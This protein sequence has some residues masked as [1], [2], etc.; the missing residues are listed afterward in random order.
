LPSG[1]VQARDTT[2]AA[3]TEAEQETPEAAQ[4]VHE[5]AEH[6]KGVAEHAASTA[7]VRSASSVGS[8]KKLT[9]ATRLGDRARLVIRMT[10]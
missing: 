7:H 2:T 6:T 10:P 9:R 3:R 5:T 4:Q 8:R 1:A